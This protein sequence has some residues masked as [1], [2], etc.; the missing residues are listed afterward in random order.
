MMLKSMEEILK[1]LDEKFILIKIKFIINLIFL[2][3]H[4]NIIKSNIIS[5]NVDSKRSRSI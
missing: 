1:N 4:N 3:I 2:L 5:V